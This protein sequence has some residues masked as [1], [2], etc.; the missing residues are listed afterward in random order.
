MRIKLKT[1]I[2]A[3]I[4]RCFDLS[5][6]IDLHVASTSG[7][8]ELAI[9]GRTTGLIGLN[10]TVTW[11]GRHF[12]LILTHQS[13]I[14]AYDRP[15]HFQDS[16]VRGAFRSFVHDHFF[17]SVGDAT[18]MTDVVEFSAPLGPLGLLA[19]NVFLEKYMRVFLEER[20]V[21]VKQIAESSEW[22]KYLAGA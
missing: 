22:A 10:E 17:E 6:S 12:C 8:R 5:R 14:T 11:K 2:T 20:N 3:P 7:T 21:F 15:R 9:A 4:E 19:E 16:M 1:T 18:L 13:R